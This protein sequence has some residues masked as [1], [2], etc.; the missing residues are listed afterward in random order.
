MF[1]ISILVTLV[2]NREGIL[3]LNPESG[4]ESLDCDCKTDRRVE[5]RKSRMRGEFFAQN[6][7]VVVSFLTALKFPSLFDAVEVSFPFCH[8]LLP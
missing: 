6:S 2:L 3:L 1:I 8:V 5:R 4:E 7:P